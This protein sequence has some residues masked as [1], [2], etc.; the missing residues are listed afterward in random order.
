MA[1]N[2]LKIMLSFM[3]EVNDGNIPNAS[4]YKI[5]N[6]ELW[7]IIDTYKKQVAY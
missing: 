2:K 1:V 6:G 7:D 5:T 4:D 3:R